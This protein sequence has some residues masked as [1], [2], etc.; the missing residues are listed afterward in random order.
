[1]KKFLKISI[2]ILL[3]I[4]LQG[5]EVRVMGQPEPPGVPLNHGCNG[6]ISNNPA[7]PGSGLEIFL[8]LG[9]FY[10]IK[11]FRNK[12]ALEVENDHP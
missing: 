2:L 7:P 11:T 10:G 8:L 3:S 1:M 12:K 6:N 5:A 4:L 9:M